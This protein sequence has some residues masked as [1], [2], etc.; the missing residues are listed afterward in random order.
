ML[1]GVKDLKIKKILPVILP[2]HL[3]EFIFGWLE[4]SDE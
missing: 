2:I 4:V 1:C 3:F